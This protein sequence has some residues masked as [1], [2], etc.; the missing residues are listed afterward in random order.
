MLEPLILKFTFM[1]SILLTLAIGA[2]PG[3][4]AS[5][6]QPSRR[7]ESTTTEP[8]GEA[9]ADD[10]SSVHAGEIVTVEQAGE[11]WQEHCSTCH[12]DDGK[13]QSK[14][15]QLLKI[16][17]LT[18]ARVRAEFDRERMKKAIVEG[19]PKEPGSTKFI[20]KGFADILSDPQ[21]EALIDW[22]YA[23]E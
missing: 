15:S 4:Q 13:A 23:L 10:A 21:V 19:V 22:V 11:L 17:D 7:T 8:T 12:G 1:F 6:E 2:P 3:S 18:N 5:D 14:L 20:K 9:T 16:R